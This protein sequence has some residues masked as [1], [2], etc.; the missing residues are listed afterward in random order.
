M[1]YSTHNYWGF[2]PFHHLMFLGV[3]TRRFGKLIYFRR[4][5]KGE[6][7]YIQLGSIEIDNPVSEISSFQG[8]RVG[9][10][11]PLPKRH[12]STPKNIRR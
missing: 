5:V 12:V 6:N 3:E 11:C 10:F 7:I 2:G 4:Q 9:V 8:A 1:V